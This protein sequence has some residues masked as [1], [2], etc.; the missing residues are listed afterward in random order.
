LSVSARLRTIYLSYLSKPCSDRLIYRA[1]SKRPIRKILELGIGSHRR[2][3]RMIQVA[4][5]AVPVTEICYTAIDRF[6]D[7]DPVEGASLTLKQVHQ[8]IRAA[9]ARARLLP[10]DPLFGLSAAANTLAETDLAVISTRQG[11]LDSAWYYFPR[12]LHDESI[13]F[14]EKDDPRGGKRLV[15]LPL[16]EIE[17][18]ASCPRLRRAA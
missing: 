3:L 4:S 6:E 9:G 1:I 14:V 2:T 12:M 15:R 7:R 11:P 8:S 16:S 5:L 17:R 18:L 10:G 13:V